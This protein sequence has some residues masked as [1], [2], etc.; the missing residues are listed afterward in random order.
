MDIILDKVVL[1][2][3]PTTLIHTLDMT[4][5]IPLVLSGNKK[6]ASKDAPVISDFNSLILSRDLIHSGSLYSTVTKKSSNTIHQDNKSNQFYTKGFFL[7]MVIRISSSNLWLS[8]YSEYQQRLFDII[9]ELHEDQK[10]NFVQIS[11]WL[12]QNN[13]LTPRG[14]VFS[15]QLAWSL[16]TKKQRSIK[17]FSRSFEPV[18]LN[19]EVEVVNYVPDVF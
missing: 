11:N 8:P 19:S 9:R 16:Y 17:R 10:M 14:K 18:I 13:Y 7:S 5:R 15:Q 12:N 2:H 6:G 1:N 4:L 3:D